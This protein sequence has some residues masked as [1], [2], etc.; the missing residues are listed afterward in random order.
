MD[1]AIRV[2]E[3]RKAHW[4]G[5]GWKLSSTKTE[6]PACLGSYCKAAA[7]Q[8]ILVGEQAIIGTHGQL[9]ATRHG[10]SYEITTHA[11]RTDSGDGSAEE[12]P[13]MGAV[14]RSRAFNCG[15]DAKV[16]AGVDE[17][18]HIFGPT[19]LIKVSSEKPAGFI[20]E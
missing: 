5:W 13:D 8:G 14:T 20:L 17:G 11:T 10:F 7:W 4:S 2:I 18:R 19:F 15:R 1:G 16:V 9:M 3:A 6:L 12:E